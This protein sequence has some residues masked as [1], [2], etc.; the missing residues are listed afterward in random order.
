MNLRV[1]PEVYE[2]VEK[3]SRWYQEIDE[4]LAEEFEAEF[5]TFLERV[6]ERPESFR[7]SSGDYR[8]ARMSV[9]PYYLYFRIH[10]KIPIVTMVVHTSRSP[11]IIKKILR[12]RK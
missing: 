4:G 3:I 8:C 10:N 2:D 6:E 12:K 7:K 11:R 1:K 9:F 5:R